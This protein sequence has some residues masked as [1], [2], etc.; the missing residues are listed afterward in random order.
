VESKIALDAITSSLA[1]SPNR[2][3]TLADIR[4]ALEPDWDVSLDHHERDEL[5]EQM[6]SFS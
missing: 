6:F 2:D 3:F 1:T 4:R 5:R